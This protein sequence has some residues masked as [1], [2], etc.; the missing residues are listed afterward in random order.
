MSL[1]YDF[2]SVWTSGFNSYK[3][4]IVFASSALSLSNQLRVYGLMGRLLDYYVNTNMK[5]AP[6]GANRQVLDQMAN[7]KLWFGSI[8]PAFLNKD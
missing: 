3:M 8:I 6:I 5:Q 1:L 7:Q 4:L 2:K